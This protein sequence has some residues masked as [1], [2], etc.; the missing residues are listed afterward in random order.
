MIQNFFYP[1]NVSGFLPLQQKN[2]TEIVS[3][4][5]NGDVHFEEEYMSIIVQAVRPYGLTFFHTH[6]N[7]VVVNRSICTQ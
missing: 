1:Q 2:Y 4:T 5:F 7:L 6:K 3:V